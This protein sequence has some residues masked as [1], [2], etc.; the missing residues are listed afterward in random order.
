MIKS[1]KLTINKNPILFLCIIA[2]AFRLYFLLT[3]DNFIQGD[4]TA[5]LMETIRFFEWP[6]LFPHE[7]WLPLHFWLMALASLITNEFIWAPRV[8]SVIFAIAT[9]VPLYQ[10]NNKVFNKQVAFFT[11]I[12]YIVSPAI[13]LYE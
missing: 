2:S 4:A 1:I 7:R 9:V 12:L 8:V 10:L 11:T 6:S 3:T 13:G 5:R